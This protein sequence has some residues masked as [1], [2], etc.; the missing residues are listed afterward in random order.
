MKIPQIRKRLHQLAEEHGI[1]ELSRLAEATRRRP[2]IRQAPRTAKAVLSDDQKRQIDRLADTFVH[3]PMREIAYRV[4]TD[5]GR[6]SEYLNERARRQRAA[7]NLEI[8]T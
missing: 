7:P 5:Q 4:G 3:M 8:V 2:P 6:V 1:P